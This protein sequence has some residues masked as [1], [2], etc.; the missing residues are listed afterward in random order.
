MTT[1]P[2]PTIHPSDLDSV[3]EL[4]DSLG[5]E[6]TRHE[7]GGGREMIYVPGYG[8][9]WNDPE[10]LRRELLRLREEVEATITLDEIHA[11]S[12]KLGI[13]MA[14]LLHLTPDEVAARLAITD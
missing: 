14:E 6:Y 13:A 4:L 11:V 3:A 1:I 10:E 5:V 12:E 9:I 7:R 2:Q 8:E